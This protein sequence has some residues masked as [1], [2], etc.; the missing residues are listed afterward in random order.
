L[1]VI[2]HP[3]SDTTAETGSPQTLW[4]STLRKHRD[5][6][7]F[8]PARRWLFDACRAQP[9]GKEVAF[10]GDAEFTDRLRN[11]LLQNAFSG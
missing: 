11:R 3:R 5:P 10:T 8:T 4:P 6:G 1:I 9:R 7:V 2:I